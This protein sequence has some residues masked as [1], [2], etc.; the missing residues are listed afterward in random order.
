MTC[1]HQ[2]VG[3]IPIISSNIKKGFEFELFNNI[4]SFILDN[5]V[6][7]SFTSTII[8]FLLMGLII[9]VSEANKNPTKNFKKAFPYIGLSICLLTLISTSI[10]LNSI[11]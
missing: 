5:I 8:M 7:C 3:S 4:L 6:F 2:V 10:F 1:N 11:S 9:I